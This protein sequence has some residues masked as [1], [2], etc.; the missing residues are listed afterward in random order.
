MDKK[1]LVTFYT[2]VVLGE[3]AD[4]YQREYKGSS[5]EEVAALVQTDLSNNTFLGHKGGIWW[6]R[7]SE[8]VN[9]EIREIKGG[10]VDA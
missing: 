10:S 2:S 8:V 6:F 5:T 1:Y 9:F 4:A 7:S 3:E